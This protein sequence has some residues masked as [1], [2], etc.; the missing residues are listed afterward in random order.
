MVAVKTAVLQ[1]LLLEFAVL[2]LVVVKV[3]V[4]ALPVAL[5]LLVSTVSAL[6]V[7]L[8]LNLFVVM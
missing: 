2:L 4:N 5:L 1:P 6:L 3:M 8:P 7:S